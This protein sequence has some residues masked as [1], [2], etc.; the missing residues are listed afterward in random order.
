MLPKF[1]LESKKI[2]KNTFYMLFQWD[3]FQTLNAPNCVNL[4]PILTFEASKQYKMFQINRS[5]CHILGLGPY[6]ATS[7]LAGNLFSLLALK[8]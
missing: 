6:S 5:K 8:Q 7:V 4:R 3:F 1:A 2:G